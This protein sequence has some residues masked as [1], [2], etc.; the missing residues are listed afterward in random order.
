MTYVILG[1]CALC[2]ILYGLLQRRNSQVQDLTHRLGTQK[3]RQEAA[4]RRKAYEEAAKH[5]DDLKRS[6]DEQRKRTDV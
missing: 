2:A 3:M 6:Y 5:Y 4:E 1:L